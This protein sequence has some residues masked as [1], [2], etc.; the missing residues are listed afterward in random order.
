MAWEDP[1]GS[2]RGG[3]LREAARIIA[4]V[5]AAVAGGAGLLVLITQVLA[6]PPPRVTVPPH[7][8]AVA[9]ATLK[10][11]GGSI[12]FTLSVGGQPVLDRT[13]SPYQP[14]MTV[15]CAAP[16]GAAVVLAGLFEGGGS[17]P[18]A[19]AVWG[20]ARFSPAPAAAPGCSP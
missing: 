3:A 10:G 18:D 20:D 17:L 5:V 2:S 11:L 9:A 4:V 12:R 19:V 14:P 1:E 13:L 8:A 15:T 6:P 7:R 16:A